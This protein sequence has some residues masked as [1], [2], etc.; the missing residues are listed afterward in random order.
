MSV[1]IP[2]NGQNIYDVCLQTYGNLKYL[3]KLVIDNGLNG[4]GDN[5]V[6]KKINYDTA[7]IWDNALFQELNDSGQKYITAISTGQAFATENNILFIS[8]DGSQEFTYEN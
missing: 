2:C 6:G 4:I 5:V 8:E 7:L 1:Y 3:L